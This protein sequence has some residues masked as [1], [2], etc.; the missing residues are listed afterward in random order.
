[1][2]FRAQHFFLTIALLIPTLAFGQ[3]ETT[4]RVSGRVVDEDAKPIAGRA[5]DPGLLGPARRARHANGRERPVSRRAASGRPVR[6]QRGRAGQ[7]DGAGLA[8]ADRRADRSPRGHVEARRGVGGK[9]HRVRRG[10]P[11]RDDRR[12]RE[13]QLRDHGR[14]TAHRVSRTIGDVALYSPNVQ[15]SGWVPDLLVGVSSGTAISG[16]PSY[17]TVALLDGADITEPAYGGG[18]SLYLEDAVEE[19]QVLTTGISA[20]YGRFQGGVVNVTTKS[21]GNEFDGTVRAEFGKQSWNSRTPFGEEQSSDLNQ[22]YQATLGGP[23]LK[24]KLWFFAGARVVPTNTVSRRRCSPARATRW[25]RTT[26]VSSSSCVVLRLRITSSR[27]AT[28]IGITW[29]TGLI[30][31]SATSSCSELHSG[32]RTDVPV[33]PALPGSPRAKKLPRRGRVEQG[34][35][36]ALLRHRGPPH[37]VPRWIDGH[38]VQQLYGR[39]KGLD[40]RQRDGFGVLH[41]CPQRFRPRKPYGRGRRSIHRHHGECFRHSVAY[42]LPCW[43]PSHWGARPSR[44]RARLRERFSTT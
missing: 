38:L 42:R 1:M 16:A 5:G 33:Q 21:G 24:D 31:P 39:R 35:L 17:S 26:T 41:P 44:C 11:A 23:I 13:L 6:D 28:W 14:G 12:R 9:G 8:A 36:H 10:D 2:T 27:S 25:R 15:A 30:F 29:Q 3:A 20:R 18:V 19:V 40:A 37:A 7:A 22:I 43:W 4:G 32:R 34:A